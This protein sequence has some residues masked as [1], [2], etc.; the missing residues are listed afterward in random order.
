LF[1]QAVMS[2]LIG[3]VWLII[4][5][6]SCHCWVHLGVMIGAVPNVWC[7]IIIDY[8]Y[9]VLIEGEGL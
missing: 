6:G 3:M 8:A 1:H 9:V 7:I 5:F 4:Y 2:C